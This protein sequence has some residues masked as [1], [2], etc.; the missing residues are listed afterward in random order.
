L[1]FRPAFRRSFHARY[2]AALKVQSKE[3]DLV[4]R[5]S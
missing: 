5:E 1:A 4:I 2:L 3:R